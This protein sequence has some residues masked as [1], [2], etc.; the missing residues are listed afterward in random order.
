MNDKYEELVI[1]FLDLKKKIKELEEHQKIVKNELQL[2]MESEDLSIVSTSK[3]IVTM[4]SRNS[5]SVD[6]KKGFE[7]F[8]ERFKEILNERTS[9]FIMVKED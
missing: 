7:M 4:V 9:N 3:G 2:L 5:T 1:Q 8:G 6:K